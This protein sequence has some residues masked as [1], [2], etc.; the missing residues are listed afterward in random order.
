MILV[1]MRGIATPHQVRLNSDPLW[2]RVICSLC[3]I[4]CLALVQTLGE[5]L[6]GV[7]SEAS[8]AIYASCKVCHG[9]QEMQRGPI[10]DG[11]PAW[12]VEQQLRK[13][14][15]G[16]RGR[17]EANKSELLMGPVVEQYHEP[18]TWRLLAGWIEAEKPPRH[19]RTIRGNP[20]LGKV[21]FAVCAACH[22][23]EGRGNAELKAPPLD[24]QEDWYLMDQLRKFQRGWRG[25]DSRD[26]EGR[27]MQS[28][29]RMYTV[30]ELKDLVAYI[31][32]LDKA[33]QSDISDKQT[34]GET[35]EKADADPAVP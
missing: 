30:N 6:Q 22:G 26:V 35:A 15:L 10:L 1:K 25:Y 34:T 4:A 27:L 7:D 11:L 32:T 31:A 33:P 12:Y 24:V 13:F 3:L 14:S 18:E 19:V 9:T 5:D 23:P 16:I 28:I 29:A 21:R 2:R 20:E 8:R 17:N